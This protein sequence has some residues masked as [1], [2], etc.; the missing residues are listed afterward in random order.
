[1]MKDMLYPQYVIFWFLYIN[2]THL[3]HR[4]NTG[5]QEI[6]KGF[7][8][9]PMDILDSHQVLDGTCKLQSIKNSSCIA[10]VVGCT[11]TR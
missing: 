1:M 4:A 7:N 3:I 11:E 8:N 2:S 9:T 5:L 10:M 6:S